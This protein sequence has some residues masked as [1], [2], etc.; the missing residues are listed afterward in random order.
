[1]SHSDDQGLTWSAPTPIA[2]PVPATGVKRFWSVVTAQPSG[3]VDVV[4][5]ESQ[6]KQATANPADQ[7]C[8]RGGRRGLNS[9]LVDT[10]WTESIDGGATW[11][12]PYKVSTATSNWCTTISNIT[13]NFGDYIGSAGGANRFIPVWADGRNGVP[14][15]FTANGLGAGKSGK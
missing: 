9:S 14:D 2:P 10:W 13:P 12:A 1:V 11:R 4:Y 15:V 5:Y 8:N 7:E 6:E 3:N